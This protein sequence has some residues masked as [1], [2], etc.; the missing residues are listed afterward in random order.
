MKWWCISFLIFRT[1]DPDRSSRWAAEKHL[2]LLSGCW[3]HRGGLV[4]AALRHREP[5]GL[6][7]V[8]LFLAVGVP[9]V[10]LQSDTAPAP[11]LAVPEG[12]DLDSILIWRLVRPIIPRKV[13]DD[14]DPIKSGL[15]GQA[16]L[17]FYAADLGEEAR[18]ALGETQ[19]MFNHACTKNE[20][21]I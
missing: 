2:L 13:I 21:N 9:E 3:S 7:V 16:L 5:Q 15:I 4:A 1:P 14:V 8:L 20:I 10:G 17:S 11:L 6:V 12:G 18:W 19:M